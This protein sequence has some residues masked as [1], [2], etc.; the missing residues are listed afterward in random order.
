MLPIFEN[1]RDQLWLG[2]RVTI[3]F[4]SHRF[5]RRSSKVLIYILQGGGNWN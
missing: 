5:S 4:S 3:K 2:E 1:P